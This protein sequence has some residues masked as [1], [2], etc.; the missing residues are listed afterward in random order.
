MEI[1]WT[2]PG[3][4]DLKEFKNITKMTNPNNYILKLI[5]NVNL[6]SE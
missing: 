5:N 3:I 6:L 1:N 2:N 4:Q